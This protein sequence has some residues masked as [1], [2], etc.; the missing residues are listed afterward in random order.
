[1]MMPEKVKQTSWKMSK[2]CD[3]VI[4]QFSKQFVIGIC[5]GPSREFEILLHRSFDQIS[6]D[7][8]GLQNQIR[9]HVSHKTCG[10]MICTIF[11]IPVPKEERLFMLFIP[12]QQTGSC[13]IFRSTE[14]FS[15]T[16]QIPQWRETQWQ[17]S[18]GWRDW[19]TRKNWSRN[20]LQGASSDRSKGRS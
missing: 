5:I 15:M 7:C 6:T 16:S 1:M 12:L 19:R 8:D 4:H 3:N 9:I 14:S 2:L 17:P 20:W 11:R 13:G 10:M 18:V